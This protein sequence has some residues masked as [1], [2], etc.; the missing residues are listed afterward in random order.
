MRAFLT[1]LIAAIL[2]SIV[3]G[4]VEG[5]LWLTVPG[6]LAFL[7]AVAYAVL[8]SRPPE[9]NVTSQNNV[10]SSTSREEDAVDASSV[11][12]DAHPPRGF[13]GEHGGEPCGGGDPVGV[14]HRCEA[15]AR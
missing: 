10:D 11:N 13:V 12:G 2:L 5:F 8:S 15:R 6:I 4:S 3:G 14:H 1:L 7:G 9:R